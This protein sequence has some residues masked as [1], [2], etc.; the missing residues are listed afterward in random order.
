[1]MRWAS[2]IAAVL[3]GFL[4]AT[5]AAAEAP[6][7]PFGVPVPSQQASQGGEAQQGSPSI[8]RSAFAWILAEQQRVNRQLAAAVKDMKDGNMLE[9]TLVL[10]F[11]SFM[12]GVLHAAGPGHGKAVISSYVLANERTVRRGIMLSFLAAGI[13]AM[14]AI[15]IVGVLA[16][17]LNATSLQIRSAEAWI[18]TVSWGF[19]ALVG[20]WLLWSQIKSMRARRALGEHAHGATLIPARAEAHSHAHAHAHAHAD[21]GHQH[22]D[23]ACCGHDHGPGHAHSHAGHGHTQGHAQAHAH[24]H[25]HSHDGACCDHAHMPDPRQLEGE[26]SWR[27]ALAIAFSVGIRPCTGAILVM[28]FALSQGIL[29][30]G[31]FSTFAMAFGTAIT[32]SVLAS[33]A[34]GSRELAQRVAGSDSGWGGMVSS[35]AGLL[36]SGLVFAMGISFFFASLSSTGTSPL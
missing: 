18:E 6:K 26:L 15:V 9:G 3:V 24:T 31:V 1:M 14:S 33:L 29:L 19:V 35:G 17:L 2:R 30:A 11:L 13:Q 28:I 5:H 21:A 10:A 12:Y 27:K 8:L 4:I 16:I 25:T 7:S 36:G 34:L 32:V 22:H 20:L 23:G